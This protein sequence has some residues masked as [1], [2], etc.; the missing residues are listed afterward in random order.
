MKSLKFVYNIALISLVFALLYLPAYLFYTQ[1]KEYKTNV[2]FNDKISLE[3]SQL[4]TLN[5]SFA[6]VAKSVYDNIIDQE[7]II[8]IIKKA[9]SSYDEE[10]KAA[11]RE[12]LY[13][14][15]RPLYRN[16]KRQNISQL[17]FHLQGNISFLRFHYPEKFGD[18]LV[19]IR[20]SIDKVNRTQQAVYGFEGGRGF[21]GFRHVFPLTYNKKLIGTV[22]ISHS[23][24][25]L[26]EEA[27]QLFPAYYAFLL[28]KEVINAKVWEKEKNNYLPTILSSRYLLDKQTLNTLTPINFSLDELRTINDN[29]SVKAAKQLDKGQPFLLHTS[30]K[31]KDF[32]VTFTPVSNIENKQIAYY[33]AYQEDH[34]LKNINRDYELQ[35]L[36]SAFVTLAFSFLA[37]MYYRASKKITQTLDS[38]ATTDPLTNVANRNQ[39]HLVMQPAIQTALRYEVPLSLIYFDIDNFKQLNDLLGP[40][41]VDEILI[42]LS[43]LVKNHIRS[44]DLLARWGGNEFIIALTRTDQH[45]AEELA[46][47]LRAIIAD[48]IFVVT[49]HLTCSFGVAQLQKGDTEASL[50]KRADAAL[51]SAKEQGK[52]RVVLA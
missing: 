14:K 49:T 21:S 22:E 11:L 39:F 32:T 6:M 10:E 2:Y 7:D 12:E 4:R 20:P 5:A 38:L 43:T 18:T 36:I 47:K 31:N 26:K 45:Q 41:T 15:L 24:N 1:Q 40:A 33:V 51:S 52:N 30:I 37:V 23:F 3:A 44:S 27:M 17:Q 42:E 34:I 50:V 35:L 28:K 16:L 13:K 9:N 25:A 29:I 8:S 19:G 46:N 48:R